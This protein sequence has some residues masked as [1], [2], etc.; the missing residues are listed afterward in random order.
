MYEAPVPPSLSIYSIFAGVCGY[1]GVI[2]VLWYFYSEFHNLSHMD[3]GLDIN[4]FTS[5]FVN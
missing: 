2:I 4:H 5:F 1:D 3:T